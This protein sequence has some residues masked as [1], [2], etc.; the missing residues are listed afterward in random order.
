MLRPLL[1]SALLSATT[2]G[3]EP[4][5]T[6]FDEADARLR[7]AY[8]MAEES[9]DGDKLERVLSLRDAVRKAL[10]RKDV[11][12]VERLIRDA[13]EAVGLDPGGKTMLG[14]PIAR[15]DAEL[16]KEIDAIELRLAEAM[17]K[18]DSAR[19][20]T[21][22]GEL[23][24]KLGDRAGVPDVRRNGDQ[25]K[26]IKTTPIEVAALVLKVI[27]SDPRSLKL[28]SAGVP[29]FGTMPRSYAAIVQGCLTIRPLVQQHFKDR[30][31]VVDRL[32]GGCCQAMLALQLDRGYFR[33]P[34]LRG[35]HRHYGE[36]I[37]SLVDRDADAVRD[38]WLI[39]PDPAGSTQ[40]EAAECGIALLRAGS[41]F[42]DSGWTASGRKAAEWILAQP[43][44]PALHC[45]AC[46]VS[47]LCEANRQTGLA[48]Y[49]EGARNKYRM[50]IAPG[51]AATGRWVDPKDART[52][53]HLLLLRALNDL[54]ESL[55]AGKERDE[56]AVATRRAIEPLLDEAE[57]LGAPATG[58]TVQELGR[59]LRLTKVPDLR[60]RDI[61]EQA[62]NAAIAKSSPGG[63][64]K[65]A[66]PLA[67][68]AGAAG[69]WEKASSSK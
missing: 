4:V 65:A 26:P 37:E 8:A 64:A 50:G 10:D 34:D 5:S 14:L 22:V 45:N 25:G 7:A 66:V 32:I 42:K 51:Q 24:R 68:L 15:I 69:V 9:N 43:C 16:R 6:T 13:E 12:G 52:D 21:I 33:F 30:L 38:G 31:D 19:I 53:I 48:T 56:V 60:A 57:K 39:A 67:E 35:K 36:M 49:L 40:I 44:V 1:L 59:Y 61:L 20:E 47:L 54:T 46:A 3:A 2:I 23:V 28:L 63:R 18:N 11:A 17:Q 62:A 41:A 29:T 58:H 27:Q 55:P